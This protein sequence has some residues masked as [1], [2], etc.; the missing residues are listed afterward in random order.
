MLRNEINSDF[1]PVGPPFLALVEPGTGSLTGDPVGPGEVPLS[2]GFGPR[3]SPSMDGGLRSVQGELIRGA[4]G[5]SVPLSFPGTGAAGGS[6][7]IP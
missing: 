4:R 6:S 5:I 1:V 2:A 7:S 3:P